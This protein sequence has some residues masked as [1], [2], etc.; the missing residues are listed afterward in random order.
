MAAPSHLT[1]HAVA[2]ALS[3]TGALA[4]DAFGQTATPTPAS[5]QT[6]AATPA[7]V[8]LRVFLDCGDCYPEYL[9]DQIKFIDFVRQ[10]QD[11]D[12]HL[13]SRSTETGGGGREVVLRFVGRAR[14]T[15]HDEELKAISLAADTTATRRNIIYQ[16]VQVGLLN[17]LA[18]EG[19]PRVLPGRRG[20]RVQFPNHART[21]GVV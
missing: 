4:E 10:P 7:P 6:P 21:V 13:F 3:I 14:F 15:G 5:A 11:A 18:R 1:R 8:R 12:I 9:R 20:R 19:Q 2:C 17:F 16:T